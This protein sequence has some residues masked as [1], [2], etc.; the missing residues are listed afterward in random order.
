MLKWNVIG[1]L[2]ITQVRASCIFFRGFGLCYELYM[3]RCC[4]E[5]NGLWTVTFENLL[6]DSAI[7]TWMDCVAHGRSLKRCHL[8]VTWNNSLSLYGARYGC[9]HFTSPLYPFSFVWSHGVI[10][11]YLSLELYPLPARTTQKDRWSEAWWAPVH[12]R[13]QVVS[14]LRPNFQFFSLPLSASRVGLQ[15]SP[16]ESVKN[17]LFRKSVKNRMRVFVWSPLYS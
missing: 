12:Q 10:V 15:S 8:R 1:L 5:P 17:N 9:E 14:V 13:A 11:L 4:S 7:Q 16:L 2:R 3:D 6:L